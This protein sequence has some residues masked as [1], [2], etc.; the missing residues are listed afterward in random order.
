MNKK[1]AEQIFKAEIMPYLPKNDKPALRMAWND[2]TDSLCRDGQ[3]TS[4]Q[5]QNWTQPRF[6]K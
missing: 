5:Y 3:I 2:Y 4:K 1:Q 6:I